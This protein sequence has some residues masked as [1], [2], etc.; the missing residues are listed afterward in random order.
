M[1][2]SKRNHTENK[3]LIVD[4]E[5]VTEESEKKSEHDFLLSRLVRRPV[6]ARVDVED[7]GD[8]G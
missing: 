6:R 8:D 1:S 5:G 3:E 7:Q 4:K 2:D